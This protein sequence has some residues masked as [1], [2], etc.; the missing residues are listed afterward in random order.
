MLRKSVIL[1]TIASASA[2]VAMPASLSPGLRTSRPL[3]LRGGAAAKMVNGKSAKVSK[4]SAG[5][6]MA[7]VTDATNASDAECLAAA[8]LF[9]PPSPAPSFS[10]CSGGVNNIVFY[11]DRPGMPRLVLRIYNNGK[12]TARVVYEHAVLSLVAPLRLPFATPKCLPALSDGATFA[13]LPGGEACCVTECIAGGPAGNGSAR[14]IGAATAT[15]VRAM[16]GLTV[17]AGVAAVNPLYRNLYDA[18]HTISPSTFAALVETEQFD[19]VR[20]HID[21]LR[22]AIARAEA[23]IVRIMAMSPPLPT[24]LINADLHTDNVLVDDAGSVTGVLDFE[25]CAVSHIMRQLHQTQPRAWCGDQLSYTLE[26]GYPYM[27][28]RGV[29]RKFLPCRITNIC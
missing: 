2:F 23:L 21:F 12:N 1:A 19:S 14:S 25:F 3:S 5:G 9:L 15:L 24:Q 18:H 29:K 7:V 17:P 20:E 27:L 10:R 28:V 13:L 26:A 22:G 8:L 6:G 11:I 4:V 16:E